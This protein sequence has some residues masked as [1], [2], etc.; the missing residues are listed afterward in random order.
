MIEYLPIII[1]LFMAIAI[2]L[3]AIFFSLVL[4]EK[5]LIKKKFLHMNVVLNLFKIQDQSLKSNST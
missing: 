3:G 2:S 4:G 5:I 1:F